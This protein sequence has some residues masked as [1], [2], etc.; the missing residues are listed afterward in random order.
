MEKVFGTDMTSTKSANGDKFD[1]QICNP[2]IGLN[3]EF[4]R[5]I[6]AASLAR[7]RHSQ[8]TATSCERQGVASTAKTDG[9]GTASED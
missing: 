1:P 7:N 2:W 3:M 8:A 9:P 5:R 4:D 6:S